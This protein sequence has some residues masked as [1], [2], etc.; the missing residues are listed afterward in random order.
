MYR[1]D[2]HKNMKKCMSGINRVLELTWE[3]AE[4]P[5]DDKIRLQAFAQLNEG[6][7]FKM[8]LTTN[9]VVITDAIKFVQTNKE[10]LTMS[11]KER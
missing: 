8:N 2:Y 3:I 7:K 4:K 11:T 10:K 9:G 5:T 6:Y 1:D